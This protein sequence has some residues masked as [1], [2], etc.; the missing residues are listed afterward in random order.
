MT[1]S[2]TRSLLLLCVLAS[3]CSKPENTCDPPTRSS[4]DQPGDVGTYW[5]YDWV[6]IL[7]DGSEEPFSD[8]DTMW[9]IGT[10]VVD[11]VLY[12]QIKR[13][14]LSFTPDTIWM[15]DNG[16]QL[17]SLEGGI[18]LDY[19]TTGVPYQEG[20]FPVEI[21]PPLFEFTEDLP[22]EWVSTPAG[23]FQARAHARMIHQEG[24]PPLNPCEDTLIPE[25]VWYAEGIGEVK[26]STAFVGQFYN[27]CTRI[28]RRLTEY[29]I[30]E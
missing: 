27:D 14:I 13:Q 24:F 18:F 7:A 5:V 11:D 16:S 3:A 23:E 17:V 10:Q 21:E 19:V 15:G 2:K 25:V 12:R 1:L 26:R 22:P 28:E 8:P 30:L 9:V 4:F 29:E 20:P 6:Q